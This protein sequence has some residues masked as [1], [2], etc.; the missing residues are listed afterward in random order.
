MIHE[1]KTD[2][3]YF[4]DVFYG[5]KKFEVRRNDRDFKVGDIIKL[6][7]NVT[8]VRQRQRYVAM[9]ISYI[10]KG[11]QHGIDLQHVVIGLEEI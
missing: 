11:G 9:R 1:L 2:Q 10:L 6:I 8:N 4:N 5:L 7:E 3:P